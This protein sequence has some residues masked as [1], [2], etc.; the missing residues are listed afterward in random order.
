MYPFLVGC[1]GVIPARSVFGAL[2]LS[3][4]CA[5]PARFPIQAVQQMVCNLRQILPHLLIG[6]LVI[7]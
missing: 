6:W 4:Y 5:K 3:G 1:G 7:R 2:L